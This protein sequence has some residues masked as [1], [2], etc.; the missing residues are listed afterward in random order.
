[1]KDSFTEAM[2]DDFNT[3]AALGAIFSFVSD[4]NTLLNDV[5][6]S[7]SVTEADVQTFEKAAQA[8]VELMD[9]L[10]ISIE[11]NDAAEVG[12]TVLGDEE[13]A[14]EVMVLAMEFAG[15]APGDGADPATV[16]AAMAALLDARANARANKNYAVADAIR[17]GLA[18]L[19][20]RIEDTPQGAR[21]VKA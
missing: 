20:F 6:Q 4:A 15:F 7:A 5:Q 17:D 3:A 9:V 14:A 21:I 8:V 18:E 11:M 1:M 13:S 12:A 16:K 19:G 2:D 10:G